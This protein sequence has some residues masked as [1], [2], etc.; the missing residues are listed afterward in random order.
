MI[1]NE[2]RSPK[3]FR[4]YQNSINLFENLRDDNINPKEVLKLTLNQI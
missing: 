3:D 1:T 2:V 4:N